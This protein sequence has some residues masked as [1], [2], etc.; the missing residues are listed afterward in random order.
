MGDHY[1]RA[2]SGSTV[3][4][5]VSYGRSSSVTRTY[6]RSHEVNSARMA[7]VGRQN[8]YVDGSLAIENEA[9]PEEEPERRPQRKPVRAPEQRPVSMTV[10]GFTSMAFILT[11]MLFVSLFAYEFISARKNVNRVRE[12]ISSLS[13]QNQEESRRQAEQIKLIDD[14]V[15]L[16]EVYSKAVNKLGMVQASENVTFTYT[17]R[18]SDTVKQY[19]AIPSR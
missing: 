5:P 19:S 17:D 10:V 18:Q 13:S 7:H 15:D 12:E 3:R 1:R 8:D 6:A 9:L 14:N 2:Y 11:L 4:R 16:S